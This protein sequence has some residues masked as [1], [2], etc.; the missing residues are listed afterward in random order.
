[1][2]LLRHSTSKGNQEKWVKDGKCYKKDQFGY[3]SISEVLVS[4]LESC[5]EGFSYADYYLSSEKKYSGCCY[6][7]LFNINGSEITLHRLLS[8]VVNTNV[9]YEEYE[10]E[11]FLNM[12]E[13]I[14]QSEYSISAHEYF[15]T[16]CKLDSITLNDDRHTNNISFIN[17]GSYFDFMPV[18]DNGASL[19]SDLRKYPLD[20]AI[21]G[22]IPWVSSKPFNTNFMVQ[23]YYFR[24]T[25]PLK[26]NI[27]KF[28]SILNKADKDLGN[29]I[30]FKIH[31]YKRAKQVLLHQLKVTEGVSWIRC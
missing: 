21:N 26:I 18:Y 28:I 23:V 15:G 27:D 24:D 6:S 3:E 14:L 2:E 11:D 17:R 16:I 5:I 8:Q 12:V 31:C 29:Y 1:M 20:G 22:Y 25:P 30:P 10:N 7:E 4:T 13:G 9:L 19:L